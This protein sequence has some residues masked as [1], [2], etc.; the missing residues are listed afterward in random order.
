MKIARLVGVALVVV[1]AVSAMVAATASAAIPKFTLPITK[2]GIT[3][4][5]GTSILRTPSEKDVVTCSSS[6][7]PGTILGDDEIDTK[8]TY[9]NCSLEQGTAG[10]CTIKSVGAA[11]SNEIVTGLLLGLLGELKSPAGAA[12]IL[13][14]PKSGHVFLTLSATTSPCSTPETAIEGSVAGLLT[15]TGKKSTTGLI[16]VTPVSATG[17]QEVT[18]ITTLGG[19]IKPKLL[20]FAAAE[21]TQQQ[22]ASVKFEEAV[23]VT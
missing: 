8:I 12:G 4:T 21:S 19:L 11:G 20:A 22:E 18:E 16:T 9:S 15:P 13:F 3:A 1:F 5:S 14:E 10:P 7:A 2:R 23:E 6:N 17:K